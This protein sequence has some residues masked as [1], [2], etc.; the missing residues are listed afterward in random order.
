[1]LGLNTCKPLLFDEADSSALCPRLT[2]IPPHVALLNEMAGIREKIEKTSI[3]L[4]DNMKS[5]LNSRGIG[6]EVFQA[7]AILEEVKRVT[8]NMETLLSG[9]SKYSNNDNDQQILPVTINAMAET[10]MIVQQGGV[11]RKMYCW[12]G[13][14]HNLPENYVLPRMTLQTLISFWFC[15]SYQP[16]VPPLRFARAFDFARKDTMKVVLS[17]MKR[18]IRAILHAGS[19]KGFRYD[20][21]WTTAKCTQLYGVVQ[22]FFLYPSIRHKRRYTSISWKTYHNQYVKNKSL[23]VGEVAQ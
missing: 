1:M 19:L 11:Q 13:Q 3:L 15:G 6:G 16:F 22:E 7:N 5:E 18:M 8:E 9:N 10:P 20:G 14:L 4:M 21:N 17:Q 2:G 12:G 23:L